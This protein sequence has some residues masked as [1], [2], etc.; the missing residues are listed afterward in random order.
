MNPNGAPRYPLTSSVTRKGQVTIPAQIRRLLALST[1]DKVAFLVADG[2]VQI[3]PA[4]S[5]VA[6]TAGMLRSALPRLAPADE[7]AAAE[8][9]IAD[10]ASESPR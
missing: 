1:N 8:D 2:K 5:V 3:A 4:Q 10:E 6:R 7:E 9:A